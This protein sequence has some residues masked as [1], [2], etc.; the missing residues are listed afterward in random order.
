[1]RT[2]LTMLPV[3]L[4]SAVPAAAEW[5]EA[6]SA[7]FVIYADDDEQN[8]SR[9]SGQLELYHA[10]LEALTGTDLPA[11]GPSNRLTIFVVKNEREVRRLM[12]EGPRRISG[13]YRPRAGASIA[14]VPRV[15]TGGEHTAFPMVVLLHEYTHH[16][17]NSAGKLLGPRWYNEGGAEYFASAQ[18]P[19][20]G[21]I[22]LG[23][24]ARHRMRALRH[25]RDVTVSDLL[26]PAAFEQGMEKAADA[27][28]ARSWLLYH[29]L[30]SATM[31]Q[32]QM[33]AYLALLSK[34]TGR[35]EAARQAFGDLDQL[36]RELDLYLAEPIRPFAVTP[37]KPG[38]GPVTMRRLDK[39]EA[40]VMP[41]TMRSRSG[42]MP[43]QAAQLV[44]EVRELAALYPQ[45]APVLSALA[46]AEVDA[47]NMQRA[48]SAA[49][50]A[51]E[52]DPRQINAY[53]Q[54]GYAMFL[55]AARAK[56]RDAAYA[57]AMAPF[58]ALSRL[59][60][61][62][63]LPLIYNF[64]SYLERGLAPPAEAVQGM[65]RAIRLAPFDQSLRFDLAEY[66]L[67]QSDFP[68]ARRHLAAIAFDPH[69]DF[70]SEAAR[71]VVS[72]IDAGAT[73]KDAGRQLAALLMSPQAMP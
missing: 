34:G 13:F 49:D 30:T 39:A 3:C 15:K 58:M 35:A 59:E 64:H 62:H 16:F 63:P 45:S 23:G 60:K 19:A 41:L 33:Q 73:G 10:A 28:Y 24:P 4:L 21:G 36:D 7:N 22:L 12:G 42:G 55:Q 43:D 11:P 57:A 29:Y 26:D 20:A 71:Q 69:G 40:A 61:D 1:M 70:I 46:E 48:I 53:V 37:G 31:R 56:D 65:E 50:R 72:R 2:L 44:V 51:I 5:R 9:F 8:L 6:S 18:F 32:G 25:G 54:K 14:V 67:R 27:F 68:D 17:L 52:L 38:T 66:Y 47:G